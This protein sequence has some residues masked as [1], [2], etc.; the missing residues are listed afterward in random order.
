VERFDTKALWGFPLTTA[1]TQQL[2]PQTQRNE[3][4]SPW[5][6]NRRPARGRKVSRRVQKE[7][8][9]EPNSPSEGVMVA[10]IVENGAPIEFLQLDESS[11]G[12]S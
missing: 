11:R 9:I 10:F 3:I 4:S 12:K 7:I 6:S 8:L 5:H 1:P 2:L